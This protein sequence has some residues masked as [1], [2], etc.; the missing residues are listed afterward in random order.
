[1]GNFKIEIEAVGDHGFSRETKAGE[2]IP[3]ETAHEND[4]DRFA[5]ETTQKLK[6]MGCNVLVA[7]LT[8]WPESTPIVDDLLSGRRAIGNFG[9]PYAA[10]F[11]E[12]PIL[13]FFP[14][15]YG[16]D[17]KPDPLARMY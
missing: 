12:E 14:M 7:E 9:D 10:H 6:A 8:H 4:P 2:S 11:G 3:Y 13:R 17:Q 5:F 1:V 16:A 15:A